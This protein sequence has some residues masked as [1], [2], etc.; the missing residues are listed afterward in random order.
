MFEFKDII[1]FLKF[2]IL[3]CFIKFIVK[4]VSLT[5]KIKSLVDFNGIIYLLFFF[6]IWDFLINDIFYY[7]ISQKKKRNIII[8][9]QK[10]RKFS[11]NSF[12]VFLNYISVVCQ[13]HCQKQSSNWFIKR[14]HSLHHHHQAH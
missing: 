2:N 7:P 6:S 3:I 8:A 14:N 9:A 12:F 10:K 5:E 1:H 13:V 11:L 4:K